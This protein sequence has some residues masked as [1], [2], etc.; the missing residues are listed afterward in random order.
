M[1]FEFSSEELNNKDSFLSI[2]RANSIHFTHVE[3][4][5]FASDEL[6]NDKEVVLEAIKYNKESLSNLQIH[7]LI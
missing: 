3:L 7:S 6:R 2:I 4:L 1:N 5:Q